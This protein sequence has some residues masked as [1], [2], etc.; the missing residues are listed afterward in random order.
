MA[1]WAGSADILRASSVKTA[2]KNTGIKCVNNLYS[3]FLT[4]KTVPLNASTSLTVPVYV[5]VTLSP[6]ALRV[7]ADGAHPL[8]RAAELVKLRCHC[9][10]VFGNTKAVLPVGHPLRRAGISDHHRC[11]AAGRSL[12]HDMLL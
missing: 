3:A 10:G 6:L 4:D 1:A 5:T 11:R 2:I 8:R 7:F 12:A 9:R